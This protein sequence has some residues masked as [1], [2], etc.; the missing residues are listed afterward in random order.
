LQSVKAANTALALTRSYDAGKKINGRK[1]FIVTRHARI[2]D[3]DRAIAVHFVEP[4]INLR[5]IFAPDFRLSLGKEIA[6]PSSELSTAR[7]DIGA[8]PSSATYS[9]TRSP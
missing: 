3:C 8:L 7:P 1:R 5:Q 2:A 9:R 6:T 4:V